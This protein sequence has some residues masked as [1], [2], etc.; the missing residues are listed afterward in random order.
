LLALTEAAN[1]IHDPRFAAAIERGLG[2]FGIETTMIVWLGVPT[3]IDVVAVYWTDDH[4]N[5]HTNAGFWNF[6][7]G[8]T[9]RFFAALR[10]S[11]DPAVQ[12]VAAR[13][14][15]RIELFEVVL[16]W[17]IEHSL[18]RRDGTVEIRSST[19]ST[20]TNS[21]TQPWA[22]VGLLERGWA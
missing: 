8:L 12:A 16:R 20:E 11:A 19:L 1:H 21:E 15:R 18:D 2:C 22:A 14:Q 3:K 4:G 5:R 10:K 7:A 9:L 6:H 13:H 17:Q